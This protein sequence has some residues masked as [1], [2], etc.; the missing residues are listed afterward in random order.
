MKRDEE[1]MTCM[2]AYR[3]FRKGIP[4]VD[5]EVSV[6]L[7]NYRQTVSFLQSLADP[8]FHL[9]LLKLSDDLHRLEMYKQARKT[10]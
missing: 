4:M 7:K 1:L 8:V 6:L 10:R 2:D 5:E 9:Y 3:K